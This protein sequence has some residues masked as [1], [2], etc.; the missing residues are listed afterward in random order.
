MELIVAASAAVVLLFFSLVLCNYTMIQLG[1]QSYSK[2]PS[3]VQREMAV[4]HRMIV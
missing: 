2:K 1:R 4:S 3:P